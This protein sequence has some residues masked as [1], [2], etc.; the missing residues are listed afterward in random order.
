MI[1][2]EDVTVVMPC[3]NEESTIKG[4]YAFF[5]KDGY[6]AVVALAK[7]SK[8]RTREICEQNNIPFF[9][10]NG[11]GKGAALE[12]AIGKVST[13]YL[14]FIDVD[15]SHDFA[16]VAPMLRELDEKG[17]D[18][19]IGSRLMGGSMELYDGTIESFLRTFFTLCINQIVN[20]RFGSRITDTQNGFRC[21]KTESFRQLHLKAKKFEVETEMV[22]KMLKKSKRITE[23]PSREQAR[24]FGKS[25]V[26]MFWHGWRYM[27]TV[28]VNI[29]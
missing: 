2:P 5:S 4:A 1:R 11:L 8:D 20:L 9:I 25:G 3:M 23:I 16:D 29:F 14:L 6:H 12:E 24:S 13:P 15:G 21:G 19:V 26:S 22:M 28:F 17:S 7:N 10:D 18:M 27:L